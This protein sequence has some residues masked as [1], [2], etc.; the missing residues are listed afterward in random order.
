MVF[1]F[2][3][4]YYT[5]YTMKAHPQALEPGE[6]PSWHLQKPLPQGL[7][8]RLQG[9]PVRCSVLYNIHHEGS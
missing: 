5:I 8:R 1:P 3:A 2:G 7:E 4:L 6:E 9:V